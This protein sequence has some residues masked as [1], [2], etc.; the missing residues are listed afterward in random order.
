MA[1]TFPKGA[2]IAVRDLRHGEIESLL[3]DSVVLYELDRAS[4]DELGELKA[5]PNSGRVIARAG[6]SVSITEEGVF[7]NG[8]RLEEPYLHPSAGDNLRP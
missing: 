6:D 5:T 1:T 7:V 4:D 3:A 2:K 8:E